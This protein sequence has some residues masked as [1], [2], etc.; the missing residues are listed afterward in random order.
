MVRWQWQGTWRASWV[1]AVREGTKAGVFCGETVPMCAYQSIHFISLVQGLFRIAAGASKL[2]KLKAALDCSTSQLDEFY[3]DP[4]AVAGIGVFWMQ[5]RCPLTP[6]R[7]LLVRGY[8]HSSWEKGQLVESSL[9]FDTDK[10]GVPV[11]ITAAVFVTRVCKFRW[12]QWPSC[13]ISVTRVLT[14]SG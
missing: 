11:L 7:F 13:H 14:W 8:L 4:H 5:T 6:D 12:S 1:I 9:Q 10:C 2:K 3:S